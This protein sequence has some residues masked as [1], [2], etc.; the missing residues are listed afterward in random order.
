MKRTQISL[1]E[2]ERALLDAQSRRTGRSMSSLIREAVLVAYA[3]AGET[4]G[5]IARLDA[6]F[7]AWGD[8]GPD[9]ESFVEGLRTGQSWERLS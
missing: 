8:A 6:A 3:P 4:E 9:G 1:S 2:E 5:D 7:G